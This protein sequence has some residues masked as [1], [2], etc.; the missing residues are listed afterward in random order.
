MFLELAGDPKQ[1]SAWMVQT[2]GS[3]WGEAMNPH[4]LPAKTKMV[5]EII[6]STTQVVVQ[7]EH[8]PTCCSFFDAI[9]ANPPVLGHIHVAEALSIPLHIMFPQPWIYSTREFPHPMSGL[10]YDNNKNNGNHTNGM[11]NKASYKVFEQLA[12][13]SLGRYINRWRV[14]DLALP[15]LHAIESGTT[16]FA[17]AAKVP[18]SAMWSPTLIPKPD[19]WPEQCRVV[20]AFMNHKDA[21]T[22]ATTSVE[23]NDQLAATAEWIQRGPQPIF[24]GFGSMVIKDPRSLE[25]ILQQASEQ[26]GTRIIVQSG[27]TKL[28]MEHAN[29]DLVHTVG[30]CPHDWLFP[31]S[32]AVIHH[33]GA[34][35]TAAGLRYGKPTLI[36]PFFADQFMWGHFVEK[37]GVG[38]K[39]CRVNA[40]TVEILSQSLQQLQSNTLQDNARQMTI[41]ILAED[42]I[43]GGMQH[44][45]EAFT[46]EAMW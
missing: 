8:D 2:K 42:G 37:A 9:I 40:L 34:G 20:G 12:W 32:A 33:G 10:S 11:A 5:Q 43:G 23:V 28:N 3:V 1:L 24:I 4:L 19:D 39:A 25:A 16:N 46:R 44:F 17:A 22:T 21:S 35:T 27:W 26:T 31:Q 38:P 13:S 45:L 36:C 7:Q 15:P 41:K 30:S 29:R 6:A 14:R 18:F